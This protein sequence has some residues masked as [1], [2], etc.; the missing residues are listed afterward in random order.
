MPTGFAPVARLAIVTC[1]FAAAFAA[2]FAAGAQSAPIC[3]TFVGED[4]QPVVG[5]LVGIDDGAEGAVTDIDGEVCL[6]CADSIYTFSSFYEGVVLACAGLSDT[7]VVGSVELPS[8]SVTRSSLTRAQY[9]V[10]A[11]FVA[12]NP[13]VIGEADLLRSIQSLPGIKGASEGQ[14]APLI[15]GGSADQTLV[16]LDGVTLFSPSH[17]IGFLG[18][19]NTDYV[20]SAE[21][22]TANYP[23]R[24]GGRL[25]GV[26]DVVSRPAED[27]A[28]H[29]K[30]GIGFPNVSAT[31]EGPA[32]PLRY[33]ASAR[34]SFPSL[35]L[36]ATDS[37]IAQGDGFAKLELPL[38]GDRLLSYRAYANRDRW[39]YVLKT[40]NRGDDTFA[41]SRNTLSW[42]N[43]IHSVRFSQPVGGGALSVRG[44]MSSYTSGG[45]RV[46]RD[47]SGVFRSE[48]P[49]ARRTSYELAGELSDLPLGAGTFS[50]AA[51]VERSD[52][53]FASL[54]T[55]A[56]D[57]RVGRATNTSGSIGIEVGYPLAEWFSVRAGARA[58]AIE[59]S[60][61]PGTDDGG[62]AAYLEP[63]VGV[64][65]DLGPIA[66]GVNLDYMTQDVHVLSVGGDE[67][68]YQIFLPP[69]RAYAA[70][71]SRQLSLAVDKPLADGRVEWS[72]Q[73]YYKDMSHLVYAPD[74][75][76]VV[77]NLKT[78][79]SFVERQD[80]RAYGFEGTARYRFRVIGELLASYTLSRS[81]RRPAD[82]PGEGWSRF[83]WDRLH[84]LTLTHSVVL[85]PYWIANAAFT[86][87]SGYRFSIPT[88]SVGRTYLTTAPLPVYTERYE[89][90]GPAHHRLDLSAA[91]TWSSSRF[92]HRLTFSVYNAYARANPFALYHDYLF[93]LPPEGD[94]FETSFY[95]P[96]IERSAPLRFIPGVQY[97]IT[98]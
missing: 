11:A 69:S 97:L 8:V 80:G 4:R 19:I 64:R 16:V 67:A 58:F 14:V 6:R 98:L 85:G 43:N 29:A 82:R 49:G 37:R 87:Q 12:N 74:G 51:R 46:L 78:E 42:G 96:T 27:D 23:V 65:A 60:A 92:E 73:A 17:A 71:T 39:S 44:S 83:R 22:Y 32:G 81:E 25:S 86:Y 38:R 48:L 94:P 72:A 76:R 13:T 41:K 35:I 62:V 56:L 10:D 21:V 45:V 75:A 30:F 3:V 7:V 84:N 95:E 26:V 70:P 61:T 34:A 54:G 31:V 68:Y 47:T 20:R 33:L 52:S 89:V 53:R 90:E 24:Y 9:T 93:A 36:A 66:V 55:S 28:H 57:A 63:R 2:T 88:Y 1:T 77:P 50:A 5:L 91:R 79:S 40:G 18:T 15:R 59:E